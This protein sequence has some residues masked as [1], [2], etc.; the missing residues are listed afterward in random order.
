MKIA[1]VGLE[2]DY[3]TIKDDYVD[4]FNKYH[5]EIP[6]YYAEKG[7]NE[8]YVTVKSL[9]RGDYQ[10][11]DVRA[12][13]I[14]HGTF[15]NVTENVLNLVFQ[16]PML[17]ESRLDVVVH[18]RKWREDLY[19]RGA[20]NL[21]HTCDHTYPQVWKDTVKKAF[22]DKKLYGILCYRS[23]HKRQIA[24][25]SGIPED[26]LFTD[27]TFG[28]DVD[29]YKPTPEKDPYQMLWSSDPGR[30]L[31]GA[32]EL[33]VKLFSIDKRFRLNIC[34]PDYVAAPA[35]IQ[36]PALIWHG[37][38]P[39]GPKLWD[40]FNR[41]GI[42]PYTSTF[43]E[44]SSR[45]HRQAQAA[46]S[47]VLYPPDMGSPSELIENDVTGIVA[48]ISRWSGII[49]DLVKSGLWTEYGVNARRFAEKQTWQVQAENFNNL[50]QD[51]KEGKR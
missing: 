50:I 33:A 17:E 38:V 9:P 11:R 10:D 35:R 5:L 32:I 16:N 45:A 14:H 2:K 37:S 30:G 51:I 24:E 4:F 13:S 6:W 8:V 44:P 31:A 7:G 36:H 19:V 3:T 49:L 22:D 25:E 42:L 1:F 12:A 26:R 41:C 15:A 29:I 48:P 46:G 28:V 47:L 39:N 34:Y 20:I 40:L 27:C 18:W 43:K 21:L 23:W